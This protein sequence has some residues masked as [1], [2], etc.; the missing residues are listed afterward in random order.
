MALKASVA[1]AYSALGAMPPD[2]TMVASLRTRTASQL[3]AEEGRSCNE[4]VTRSLQEISIWLEE[5]QNF[6]VRSPN[7]VRA[8]EERARAEQLLDAAIRAEQDKK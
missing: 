7:A 3:A 5:S 2:T 1:P 6:A 4:G 8:N